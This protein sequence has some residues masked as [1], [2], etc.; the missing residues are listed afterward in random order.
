MLT[1]SASWVAGYAP[2]ATPIPMSRVTLKDTLKDAQIANREVLMSL[3]FTR[4]TCHFT[5]TANLTA[6]ETVETP[7]HTYVKETDGSFSTKQGFLAAGDDAKA[8]HKAS[9]AS[10]Q[11]ECEQLATCQGFCFQAVSATP[12]APIQCY[13]KTALHFTAQHS[14]CVAPG[15]DGK[16][17]CAPLP[18]EMGLGGYYGHYQGHWLSATAFLVNATG[19]ATVAAAAERVMGVYE[20]VMAAWNAKCCGRADKRLVAR[21]PCCE[22][23]GLAEA[24]PGPAHA[25]ALRTPGRPRSRSLPSTN[26]QARAFCNAPKPAP[27]ATPPKGTMTTATSSRTTLSCGTSCSR[28]T[29]RARTTRCPFTPCTS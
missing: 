1:L 24:P 21:G 17:G 19:N 13:M 25:A 7:W 22:R 27:F 29:A 6:C 15:G 11:S 4:L 3:N 28:A 8:P 26:G 16:P 5:S 20:D 12:S 23:A 14:N 10:C 18:G 2:T 9:F